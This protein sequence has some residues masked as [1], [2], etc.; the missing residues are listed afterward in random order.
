MTQAGRPAQLV[1]VVGALDPADAGVVDAHNHGWIAPVPGAR[2]GGWRRRAAE[3]FDA[4]TIRRLT[5][6]NIAHR[7]ARKPIPTNH[8]KEHTHVRSTLWL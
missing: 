2:C 1:T 5:G 3:G 6:E 7:L 8:R 4:G